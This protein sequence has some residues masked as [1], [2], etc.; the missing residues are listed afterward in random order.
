[1]RAFTPIIVLAIAFSCSVKKP[2]DKTQELPTR[3]PQA[4]TY[5][6]FVQSFA[7]SNGDGIGDLNGLTSKLDYIADL[8]VEAIWLMPINP[9]P[10]YHKYDVSDYRGIHPEYGSMADFKNLLEE[11]HRRNLKIILDLVINHCSSEHPWFQAALSGD[12]KYRDFFIWATMEEIE[13]EGNLIKEATGDSDN[14]HQWNEVEGQEEL[15]FSFFWKGMP[16]LNYD[17][18]EVR[19]AVYAIGKYWLQEIGVDGFRLDA[20]RHIYPEHRAEDN[21][22][23]WK[24]FK[25]TME[26]Y[27][28]DVYLVGEVW[29]D[30]EVQAPFAA[31]F[32][33]LFNFDVSF[34]VMET[35]K[36]EQMV[37]AAIAGSAWDVQEDQSPVGQYLNSEGKFARYNSSYVNTTFLTN[38]D[39]NRVM[40]F[41]ENDEMKA[42]LAGSILL[43]MPGSPYIYYGEEL[44]MK[45]LKPDENIREPMI[46]SAESEMNTSWMK[47]EYNPADK[48]I[49]AEDQAKD[50]NSLYNHYRKLIKL[51]RSNEVLTYGDIQAHNLDDDQLMAFTRTHESNTLLIIHNLSG[52]VKMIQANSDFTTPIYTTGL[53]LDEIRESFVLKPYSSIILSN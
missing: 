24:E 44:G 43:T 7:D 40:S 50:P 46:W 21:H 52:E 26:S 49:S 33:A 38:H 48:T 23:F 35:V 18:P 9:S 25:T 11:A 28:P 5:E 39:Q 30:L 12:E 45:G 47:A 6:V 51:R 19:E 37:S 2:L 31:G 22:V 8:G 41:F 17:N 53:D 36:N 10:S 27:K 3:W 13:A 4:V 32:T 15:F 29:G 42:R 34:S 16:D 20:A 14:V 1:M